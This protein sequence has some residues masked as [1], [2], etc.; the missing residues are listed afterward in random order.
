[1][2]N[3]LFQPHIV[4]VNKK[5]QGFLVLSKFYPTIYL[6]CL[7]GNCFFGFNNNDYNHENNND[8]W[9]NSNHES[10]FHIFALTMSFASVENSVK[11]YVE[12]KID[13]FVMELIEI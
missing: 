10:A 8:D 1:M 13:F 5:K 4:V 9:S 11:M 12:S 3:I 7:I 2:Q 6:V